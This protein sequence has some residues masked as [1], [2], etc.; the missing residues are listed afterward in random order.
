[1][2]PM[3]ITP[4]EVR[5]AFSKTNFITANGL[6]SDFNRLYLTLTDAQVYDKNDIENIVIQNDGKRA[7]LLKDIAEVSIN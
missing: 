4:A 3:H 6:V 2:S 5:D 1:M 7:V